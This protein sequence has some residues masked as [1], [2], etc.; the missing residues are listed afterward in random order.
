MKRF[1]VVALF[2]HELMQTQKTLIVIVCPWTEIITF[3]SKILLFKMHLL[4][5]IKP[6]SVQ[7][8]LTYISCVEMHV[9]QYFRFLSCRN[10]CNDDTMLHKNPT[11]PPIYVDT[12]LFILNAPKYFNP[13]KGNL[14]GILLHFVSSV[15]NIRVQ[16]HMSD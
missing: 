12:T 1:S 9:L 14:Q 16:I 11:N 3:C 2:W 15:N 13:P 6:A 10:P 7:I 5:K 8:Q 4:P